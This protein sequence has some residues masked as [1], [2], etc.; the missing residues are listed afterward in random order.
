M[1]VQVDTGREPTVCGGVA[2]THYSKRNTHAVPIQFL[3]SCQVA[4]TASVDWLYNTC[5]PELGRSEEFLHTCG[6]KFTMRTMLLWLAVSG[7]LVLPGCRPDDAP[8]KGQQNEAATQEQGPAATGTREL[9]NTP[10]SKT[11][12]DSTATESEQGRQGM[13]EKTGQGKATATTYPYEELISKAQDHDLLADYKQCEDELR[14]EP[15]SVELR[16]KRVYYIY[17]AGTIF[18]SRDE[19]LQ[20]NTAFREALQLAQQL[21]KDKPQIDNKYRGF[22]AA[23]YYNGACV[24][25]L[26][27][28]ADSA[29]D[30]LNQAI[31]WGWSDLDAI[32]SDPDLENVRA[33]AEFDADLAGWAQRVEE[34]QRERAR[35][36]LAEGKTFPFTF[37][38]EDLQG[39]QLSLD[40]FKGKV[41]IVDIWGTWCPPCREEI[42]SFVKLQEKYGP[43]GL[44][45]VGLNYENAQGEEAKGLVQDFIKSHGI[46]YPCALGT[47]KIRA[48]VPQFEG[49][50]TTIFIDRTGKVR[51]MLVGAHEYSYLEA[52]VD[53]LIDEPVAAA[54]GSQ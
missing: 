32:R 52:I 17:S 43:Q 7:L 2:S 20:A 50:P 16:I 8:K 19:K 41:V 4:L 42:P 9:S 44:Q 22:L 21:V 29:K 1:K 10:H 36:D 25:S 3:D 39:S 11:P 23:V 14:E 15:D 18:M 28:Q 13:S 48:Q 30:I 5:F 37:Q 45:M 12:G 51:I 34:L 49:Y 54:E 6:V 33:L 38:V 35:D 27:G 31:D 24:T 47:E 46:N 53:I 26:G 40:N